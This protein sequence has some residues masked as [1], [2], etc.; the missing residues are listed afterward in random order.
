M[1][2][3]S[4]F[5]SVVAL[6]AVACSSQSSSDTGATDVPA[7]ELPA[8]VPSSCPTFGPGE[9]SDYFVTTSRFCAEGPTYFVCNEV[10]TGTFA[11]NQ[12]TCTKPGDGFALE[13]TVPDPGAS[14]GASSGTSGS[15]SGTSN[16]GASKNG[17]S[18][19]SASKSS[20]SG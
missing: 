9:D 3:S 19:S 13:E 6:V 8:D 14:A 7:G 2:L 17:A 5:V 11:Y 15:T 20:A 4:A 16:S 1:N 10:S 12:Y 18:K